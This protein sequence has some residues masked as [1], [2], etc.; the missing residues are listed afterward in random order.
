MKEFKK[1]IIW[2]IVLLIISYLIWHPNLPFNFS[3][4]TS[5]I[6]INVH[7]TYFVVESA[8]ILI[9]IIGIVFYFT[10]LIRM[11][12]K[13]LKNLIINGIFLLSNLLM[14]IIVTSCIMIVKMIMILPG[15][16]IYPPLSSQPQVHQGNGFEN[17][18][19]FFLSVL[20]VYILTFILVIIKTLIAL[21]NNRRIQYT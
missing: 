5:T 13:R 16:T 14:I 7:D 9:L 3:D 4:F 1:E 21:R 2:I 15:T 12:L 18:Y 20:I 11:L 17:L 8:N 6:D 10:Y 19:L